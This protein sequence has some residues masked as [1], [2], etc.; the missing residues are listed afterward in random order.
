M[1]PI[2]SKRSLLMGVV[3]CLGAGL[4]VTSSATASEPDE[5]AESVV[6]ADLSLIASSLGI[7]QEAAEIKYGEQLSFMNL[8]TYA[9]EIAP[10]TFAGAEWFTA[11]EIRGKLWFTE[12]APAA[13]SESIKSMPFRVEVSATAPQSRVELQEGMEQAS[14]ALISAGLGQHSLYSNSDLSLVTVEYSEDAANAA[15]ISELQLEQ[16]VG[17]YFVEDVTVSTKIN[18]KPGMNDQAL[19]GGMAMT[20]SSTGTLTCTSGF[21]ATRGSQWGFL[22]A[23]HCPS[24]S[25]NLAGSSSIATYVTEHIGSYGDAQ[26]HGSAD[27]TRTNTIK[28]AST[29]TLYRSITSSAYPTVGVSICN[30]GRTRPTAACGN[31]TEVN[32]CLTN[33]SGTSVCRLARTNATFTNNGDSGG[34]WYLNNTAVGI[35]AGEDSAGRAVFSQIGHVKAIL[36]TEV[37]LG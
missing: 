21:T 16:L 24:A 2:S 5:R 36:S 17:S 27:A 9:G 37:Y 13:L 23:G 19:R 12:A 1:M 14:K 28:I 7:E 6:D 11:G 31:V 33:S 34:P 4:F 3:A 30:F 10:K 35:T 32:V 26:F 25:H 8:A 22:I 20:Q 15:R 18:E 29:G